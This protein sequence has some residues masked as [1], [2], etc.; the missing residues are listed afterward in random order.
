MCSLLPEDLHSYFIFYV[1]A[2][3]V[4]PYDGRKTSHCTSKRKLY[5]LAF[6]II[7]VI[8]NQFKNEFPLKLVLG[9]VGSFAPLYD[10]T[11]TDYIKLSLLVSY[12]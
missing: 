3:G 2:A 8:L 9:G 12:L 11:K 4:V 7:R 5:F 10:S 6:G 1:T